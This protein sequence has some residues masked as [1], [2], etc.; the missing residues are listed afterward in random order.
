MMRALLALCVLAA[1]TPSAAPDPTVELPACADLVFAGDFTPNECRLEATGVALHVRF[2][3]VPAG[4]D[5]GTVSVDVLGPDFSVTQTILETDLSEYRAPGVQD[6]DGDGRGD[7]LI[8][9]ATGNA[10]IANAIWLFSGE[11]G[12]YR[13][14]GEVS[15]VSIERTAEGYV[16]VPARGGAALWNVAFYRL[17]GEGLHMLASVNVEGEDVNGAIRSSCSLADAPG[18]GAIDLDTRA[19]EAK[20]C[21]EPAAQVFAP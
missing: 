9:R 2:A 21:A 15:G 5:G 20:F 4:V 1:C 16:A 7:I 19:A 14:V 10:N 12:A 8:P 18:I 17:D 13:R 11:S 3:A 6:V